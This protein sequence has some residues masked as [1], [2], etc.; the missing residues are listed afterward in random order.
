M[1]SNN[2]L[3][4]CGLMDPE[5]ISGHNTIIVGVKLASMD[6]IRKAEEFSKIRG[7]VFS[8]GVTGR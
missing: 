4:I 5:A 7:V 8:S 1:R 2:I 3:D 6:L